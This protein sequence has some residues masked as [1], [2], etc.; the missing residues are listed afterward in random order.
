MRNIVE[1]PLGLED[2]KTRDRIKCAFSLDDVCTVD[3]AA[4]TIWGTGPKASCQRGP[5][6]PFDIGIMEE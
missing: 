1:T 4:C 6:E 3:C 5:G 2:T